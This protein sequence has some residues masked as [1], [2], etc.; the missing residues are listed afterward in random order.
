[1][2]W[3]KIAIPALRVY[4]LAQPV[5]PRAVESIHTTETRATTEPDTTPP[6]VATSQNTTS[7]DSGHTSLLDIGANFVWTVASGAVPDSS[8]RSAARSS[9]R[10]ILCTRRAELIRAL[11]N[12]AATRTG[13]NFQRPLYHGNSP[14]RK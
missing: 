1:M 10:L 7:N 8:E 3:L 4:W 14:N 5:A 11:A 9:E 6:S 12:R 2:N 13:V